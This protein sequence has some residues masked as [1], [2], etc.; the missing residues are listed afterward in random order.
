MFMTN[1]AMRD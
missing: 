1:E